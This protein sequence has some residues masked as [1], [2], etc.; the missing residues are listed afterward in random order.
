MNCFLLLSFLSI[1][2]IFLTIG[3]HNFFKAYRLYPDLQLCGKTSLWKVQGPLWFV[4]LFL[5]P[6]SWWHNKC[7]GESL[8]S[9]HSHTI[10]PGFRIL[11]H[12]ACRPEASLTA[13]RT[14]GFTWL[15]LTVFLLPLLRAHLLFSVEV[16]ITAATTVLGRK[17]RGPH[18]HTHTLP[19][20]H[21]TA[22]P[23]PLPFS[24]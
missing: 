9:C 11:L 8:L 20:L 18:T 10:S 6:I 3:T 23:A 19:W 5:L 21:W 17:H 13:E 22:A 12:A 16:T 7:L 15:L 24:R 14:A 2:L 4:L 1:F